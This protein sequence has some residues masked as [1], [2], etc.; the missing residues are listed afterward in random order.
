MNKKR[1][2]IA[3]TILYVL[4]ITLLSV[5]NMSGNIESVTIG[6]LDKLVHFCFYFSM[7]LLLMLA[8]MVCDGLKKARSLWLVTF[9]SILYGIVIEVV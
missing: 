8:V 3:V 4:L 6:H 2:I 5:V 1:I 9:A 7:N